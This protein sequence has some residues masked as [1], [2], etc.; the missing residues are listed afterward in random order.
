MMHGIKTSIRHNSRQ[1]LS[2]LVLL[3]NLFISDVNFMFCFRVSLDHRD[4]GAME[5]KT[6]QAV[7]GN[8]A[9]HS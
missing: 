5:G 3:N 8:A 9:R 7:S 2:T 6:Q 1:P 4:W